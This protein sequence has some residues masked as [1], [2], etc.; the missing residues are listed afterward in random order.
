MAVL[1]A[2]VRHDGTSRVLRLLGDG[3]ALGYA[4]HHILARFRGR[5]WRHSGGRCLWPIRPGPQPPSG[6]GFAISDGSRFEACNGDGQ[7]VV[8]R[9]GDLVDI[10]VSWIT[11]FGME[12]CHDQVGVAVETVG[13]H[14]EHLVD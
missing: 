13:E 3:V 12:P 14:L 9:S 7:F 2:S 8:H 10:D 11:E 1:V 5:D 4:A 6:S